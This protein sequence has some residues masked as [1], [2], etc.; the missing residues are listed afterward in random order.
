MRKMVTLEQTIADMNDV[1]M[2]TVP[3]S[4][5]VEI[6]EAHKVSVEDVRMSSFIIHNLLDN[7]L[8]DMMVESSKQPIIAE[9]IKANGINITM[10]DLE[11]VRYEIFEAEITHMVNHYK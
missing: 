5:M 9:T 4:K 11:A 1:V 2:T 6:C 10:E 8:I 3:M 7:G